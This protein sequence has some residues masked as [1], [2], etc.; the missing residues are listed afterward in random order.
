MYSWRRSTRELIIKIIEQLKIDD[1]FEKRSDIR[2]IYATLAHCY[3]AQGNENLL[4]EYENK[5]KELK[6]SD[7]EWE[8]YS[9]SKQKIINLKK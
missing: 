3:L 5:F 7:W 9:D 1:D 2:W 4:S 6:Q 8:T